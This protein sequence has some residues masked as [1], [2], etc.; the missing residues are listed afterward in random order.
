MQKSKIAIALLA[1]TLTACGDS[2][3]VPEATEL[4]EATLHTPIAEFEWEGLV[5]KDL[6]PASSYELE[7]DALKIFPYYN[8]DRYILIEEIFISDNSFWNNVVKQLKD[9]PDAVIRD[10]YS[11]VTLESGKTLGYFEWNDKAY[12]VSTE[13][14]PSGYVE[15]VLKHIGNQ[16]HQ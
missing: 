13:T 15:T 16:I 1:L 2:N 4:V 8:N 3:P 5:F 9:S 7:E 6:T 14:L 12:L 10:D 11:Y